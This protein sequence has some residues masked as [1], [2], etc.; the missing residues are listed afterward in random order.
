MKNVLLIVFAILIFSC[1]SNTKETTNYSEENLD[2]TTSIYPESISK[3]FDAHGGLD[4]WNSMKSLVF[5]MQIPEGKEVTTTDLKSRKSLIE[6]EKF[7]IGFDGKNVWL[8]QDSL[9]YKGNP[10]FYYNLMF[11]FYAMPFVLADDGINYENVEP[12]V[13]EGKE[14][15]GIKISYESG[16]GE[17][18]DDEY[19]LYYNSETHKMEWLG[20][21]VTYFTKEKS[22]E[23]HFIKYSNWQ[24]VDGLLLPETLTW[25]DYENNLPTTKRNDLKFTSIK[26][27]KEKPDASVFEAPEGA[28]IIE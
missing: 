27:S 20:Y 13:F 2:V 9:V 28:E 8:K 10:K 22:K 21:T 1:K 17:S 11:Y 23:F 12:L 4:K 19:F 3:V 14:Y 26:L 18:S 5:E 6:T 15:P 16:V 25:Y 7:K 24:M